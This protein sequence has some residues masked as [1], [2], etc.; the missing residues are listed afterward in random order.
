MNM[1]RIG[2]IKRAVELGL[3]VTMTSKD[4]VGQE[5]AAGQLVL[6]DAR[7]TPLRRSW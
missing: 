7:G 5:L 3:G 1:G 4:A 2:A 6:L